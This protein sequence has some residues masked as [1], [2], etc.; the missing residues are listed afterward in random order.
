MLPSQ[1]TGESFAGYPPQARAIAERNVG[2][3]GQLP[4]VFAALLLRETSTYDWRF[5]AERRLVDRQ[6]A[7]LESVA[8][9]ERIRLLSGFAAIRLPPHLERL[10]WIASPQS[11]LDG[12]TSNLWATAQVGALRQAADAYEAAWRKAI[13]EAQPAAPRLCIVVFRADVRAPNYT[14][15]RR[16]RSEG[17]FFPAVNRTD[18]WPSLLEAVA[19]RAARHPDA[20]AHWYVD[21]D[22]PD[23]AADPRLAR[24]SWADVG[25][26]REAVLRRI[27]KVVDSGHGGP[28][29]MRTLM[30]EATPADLHLSSGD[31]NEVLER[32]KISILADGSGTQ[33][34][35]TTFVQWT[36]R[37]ALRR[38][39]PITL[40]L[41]FT[42]R[43][44]QLPMNELLSASNNRNVPDPEGSLM[45]ADI[46]AFY[47]RIDQQ[48]LSG[49]ER[50]CFLAWSEAAGQ[51][52]AVGPSMPRGTVAGNAPTMRQILSYFDCGAPEVPVRT[53]EK[54]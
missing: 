22:S 1:V 19:A 53:A 11:F 5:P 48:R 6:F 40:L 9:D 2:L 43:Q 13:P 10:N 24:V 29:Q 52:V 23:P 18:A 39:E 25:P 50:S 34:F 41:R 28:E 42:P 27:Q 36:A 37:E 21:G 30:A 38:A 3:I 47:T 33:I 14:L 20:F 35:S 54:R 44:R 7:F 16:L 17:V 45:D 4:L 46:G 32:F 31:A 49:A 15:F 26:I 12:L 8:P 51:A